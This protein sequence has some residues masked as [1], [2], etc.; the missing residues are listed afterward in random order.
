MAN[1]YKIVRLVR[2]GSADG[3]IR[4]GWY[5]CFG[6]APFMV[7]F[8]WYGSAPLLVRYGAAYGTVRRSRP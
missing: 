7:R 3:S 4:F 6:S 5:G 1:G 8:C 2:F